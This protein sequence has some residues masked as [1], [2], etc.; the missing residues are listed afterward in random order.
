M[1]S[2]FMIT[3]GVVFLIGLVQWSRSGVLIWDIH[4]FFRRDSLMYVLNDK[5]KESIQKTIR[6]IEMK[7]DGLIKYSFKFVVC[8]GMFVWIFVTTTAVLNFSLPVKAITA[9]RIYDSPTTS[10]GLKNNLTGAAFSSINR[11][12]TLRSMSSFVLR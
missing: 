10:A 7:V 6:D 5:E 12:E 11:N 4:R 2:F 1:L 8:L 3:G 9:N